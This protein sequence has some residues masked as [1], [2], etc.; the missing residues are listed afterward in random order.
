MMREHILMIME[1]FFLQ[2]RG[3]FKRAKYLISFSQ[4]KQ[5]DDEVDSKSQIVDEMK[6][7]MEELK[8]DIKFEIQSMFKSN[9]SNLGITKTGEDI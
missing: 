6:Q 4:R 8:K 5:I 3:T 2:K 1:N 9:I 7:A